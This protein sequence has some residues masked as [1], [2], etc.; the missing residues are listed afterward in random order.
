MFHFFF[1]N[2]TKTKLTS[3]STVV[4]VPESCE[5]IDITIQNHTRKC[6]AQ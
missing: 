4:K 3:S 6:Q 1:L 5:T 2:F